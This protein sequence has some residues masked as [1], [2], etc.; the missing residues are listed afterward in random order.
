[1]KTYTSPNDVLTTDTMR[2]AFYQ[3]FTNYHDAWINI[4]NARNAHQEPAMIRD[5]RD[6]T[7]AIFTLKGI[8]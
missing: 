5:M 2:W 7:F 3:S 4:G 1:M 6:G 8:K